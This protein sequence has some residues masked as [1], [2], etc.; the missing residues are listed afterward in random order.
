LL[1]YLIGN[2]TEQVS[3]QGIPPPATTVQ[4][5]VV[6]GVDIGKQ[7]TDNVVSAR[8]ALQGITDVASA[9]AAIP[10]L[11]E[12]TAE[13]EKVNGMLGQLPADQ[14]KLFDG[15]VAS[16][17]AT[18]NQPLDKALAIPGVADVLNPAVNTLRTKLADLSTQSSTTG[19]GRP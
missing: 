11:Q 18:L 16:A 7:L 8:A 17:S 4:S 10:K 13:I 3:Q 6:G 19:S 5:V 9:T 15:L 14:R 1:W 12:A 2:R